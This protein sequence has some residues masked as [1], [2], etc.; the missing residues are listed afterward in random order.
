[1]TDLSV[2]SLPSK[3]RVQLLL[4]GEEI[5]I[6]IKGYITIGLYT[7]VASDSD[8]S[9]VFVGM[10]ASHNRFHAKARTICTGCHECPG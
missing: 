9:N 4:L 10:V 3:K 6:E 5:H 8:F 1:M 7:L 2:K